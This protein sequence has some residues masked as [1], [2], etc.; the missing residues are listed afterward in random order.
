MGYR[1]DLISRL[2]REGSWQFMT[3]QIQ[4]RLQALSEDQAR[5]IMVLEDQWTLGEPDAVNLIGLVSLV[6]MIQSFKG[7][8]VELD[9]EKMGRLAKAGRLLAEFLI[10]L[11]DKGLSTDDVE[12]GLSQL[13]PFVIAA[14][15]TSYKLTS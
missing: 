14:L 5:Q 2:Q 3:L 12:E 1:R 9:G 10:E 13:S 7:A 15:L 8:L 4:R 11:S 6:R